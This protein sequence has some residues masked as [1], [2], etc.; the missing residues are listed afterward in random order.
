[1]RISFSGHSN[2]GHSTA[3][4]DGPKAYYQ[5]GEKFAGGIRTIW[6]RRLKTNIDATIPAIDSSTKPAGK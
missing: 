3:N 2:A 1:M 4:S 6:A 5:L